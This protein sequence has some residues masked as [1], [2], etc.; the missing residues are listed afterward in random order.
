[1]KLILDTNVY[2]SAFV[3]DK[4]IEQLLVYC[5]ES[6]EMDIYLSDKIWY[7]IEDK[8][9]NGR[10]LEIGSKIERS[11]SSSQVLRFLELVKGSCTFI[12]PSIILEICRDP[13][14]N[15]FLELAKTVNADNI[16]TGDKDLLAL[17]NFEN[18]RIL[19]PSDFSRR[20]GLL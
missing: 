1:M 15:M 12:K 17:Q 7:E 6:M 20:L 4:A 19:K 13:K 16:V 3:F 11:I 10:V 14:D 5:L 2:I 9:L 8:F 18:T